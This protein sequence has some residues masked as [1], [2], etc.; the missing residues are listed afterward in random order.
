MVD[1]TISLTG[2][3]FRVSME[4]FPAQRGIRYNTSNITRER[5]KRVQPGVDHISFPGRQGYTPDSGGPKTKR[6]RKVSPIFSVSE[7][8]LMKIH[9]AKPKGLRLGYMGHLTLISE[10][11]LNIIDHSPPDLQVIIMKFIP[12]PEW[13]DYV[14]GRY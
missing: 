13:S 6:H 12:Q 11:V 2:L 7:K 14:N 9:S 4:Q 3:V 10:D 8:N 1:L 5:R